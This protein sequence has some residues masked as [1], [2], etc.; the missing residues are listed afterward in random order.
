MTKTAVKVD[1]VYIDNEEETFRI[2]AILEDG[3]L[4]CSE[5]YGHVKERAEDGVL[6]IYPGILTD[7]DGDNLLYLAEWGYGDTSH[8]RFH[9]L[10]RPLKVGQEVTRVDV[11]RGVEN[12]YRY[13]ITSV[14]NLLGA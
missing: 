3:C 5:M 10:K 11:H 1:L 4:C 13:R 8:T 12:E 9:F 2:H 6:K 7:Q 14:T